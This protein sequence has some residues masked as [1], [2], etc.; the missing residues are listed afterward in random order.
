MPV[1]NCKDKTK[2]FYQQKP[3]KG[4][5]QLLLT[6]SALC[7]VAEPPPGICVRACVCVCV[8]LYVC[9][10]VCFFTCVA[11]YTHLFFPQPQPRPR[12]QAWALNKASLCTDVDA[13]WFFAQFPLR[14]LSWKLNTLFAMAEKILFKKYWEKKE[15][16]FPETHLVLM[17][18]P[19][20]WITGTYYRRTQAD[21]SSL[22]RGKWEPAMV[23]GGTGSGGLRRR[24]VNRSLWEDCHPAWLVPFFNEGVCLRS[25]RK[26]NPTEKQE[27]QFLPL[28]LS[29][30]HK[31]MSLL[32]IF[33][34]IC[35]VFPK[36]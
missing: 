36:F 9:G 21:P 20:V 14:C 6:Q 12:H 24:G 25:F 2:L 23:L 3:F 34:V 30:T 1:M 11:P 10:R 17:Q 7:A 15:K 19:L 13:V 5:H 18:G 28:N 35:R 8:W 29:V 16:A 27:K 32:Q 26:K 33:P 4:G 22:S 31:K